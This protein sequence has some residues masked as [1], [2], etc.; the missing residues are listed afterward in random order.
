MKEYRLKEYEQMTCERSISRFSHTN[1][2]LT[3]ANLNTFFFSVLQFVGSGPP[4]LAVSQLTSF[5]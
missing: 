5:H 2:P 4:D 1:I 3:G